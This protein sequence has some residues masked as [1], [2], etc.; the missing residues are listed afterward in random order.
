MSTFN[1]SRLAVDTGALELP[2]QHCRPYPTIVKVEKAGDQGRV[3]WPS[4]VELHRCAGG[5]SSGRL[6][7]LLERY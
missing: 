2:M 4:F 7:F 5:C 6:F 1:L 3:Y